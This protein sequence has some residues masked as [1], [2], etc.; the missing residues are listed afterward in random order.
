M[1]WA[2]FRLFFAHEKFIKKSLAFR[3]VKEYLIH[4]FS[5]H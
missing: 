5:P 1:L 2:T 4:L 3:R